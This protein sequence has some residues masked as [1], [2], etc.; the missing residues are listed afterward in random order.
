MPPARSHPNPAFG[1][2]GSILTAEEF[3]QIDAVV[4]T[5]FSEQ[6]FDEAARTCIPK[7]IQIFVQG[8]EDLIED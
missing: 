7:K 1:R 4:V 6:Y 8:E 3:G 2:E 5:R